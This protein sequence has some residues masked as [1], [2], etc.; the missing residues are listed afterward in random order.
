MLKAV[1]YN[2]YWL[3]ENKDPAMRTFLAFEIP[4]QMIDNIIRF[5]NQCGLI[6]DKGIRYVHDNQLHITIKFCGEISEEQAESLK[7]DLNKIRFS[8]S[9]LR[10]FGSGGFPVLQRAKVLWIG[11]QH[12]DSLIRIFKTIEEI[13]DK[14]GI[15]RDNRGFKAHLTI[16]RVKGRITSELLRFMKNYERKDFGEFFPKNLLFIKSQLY[17]D[18]PIYTTLD[19]FPVH[20][21]PEL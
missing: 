16:G 15:P 10:F 17:P 2:K 7:K 4:D 12:D 14:W 18:G 19:S 3:P 11:I 8:L 5:R 21:E 1:R 9:Q 20:Y 6:Q 13:C